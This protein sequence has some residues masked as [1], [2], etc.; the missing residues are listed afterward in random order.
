MSVVENLL[1]RCCFSGFADDDDEI[2]VL[3]VEELEE[4]SP[5][6]AE[7]PSTAAV[8][9]DGVA[10]GVCPLLPAFDDPLPPLSI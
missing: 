4:P 2:V 6:G 9:G 5:N 1:C 8:Q 3:A 10:G 7:R